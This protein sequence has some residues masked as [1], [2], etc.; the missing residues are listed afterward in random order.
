MG[1]VSTPA[2]GTLYVGNGVANLNA[3]PLTA[4]A[5][6]DQ[7]YD[8]AFNRSLR[9]YP[10]YKSLNVGGLYPLGRYRRESAYVSVEKRATA[11]LSLSFPL[12]LDQAARRLFGRQAG[13][14]Q[15]PQRVVALFLNPRTGELDLHVRAA[16]WPG[17]GPARFSDWRRHLVDGWSLSGGSSYSSG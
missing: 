14:L 10:Q 6:R 15:P 8:E 11:G 12:R 3:I 4:L 2:E 16:D 7:L 9:P 5:Y 13:V 1:G 17:Q